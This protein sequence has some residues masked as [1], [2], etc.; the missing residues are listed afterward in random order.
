M[1]EAKAYMEIFVSTGA[2]NAMFTLRTT[3]VHSSRDFFFT[4]EAYIKNLSTDLEKAETLA[5]E[6]TKNLAEKIAS[7]DFE[8]YYTGPETEELRARRGKLSADE[9]AAIELIEAGVVPFGKHKNTNIS[10]LQDTYLCW[11]TDQL[12]NP[13]EQLKPAFFALCSIA[14]GVADERGLLAARQ[15]K[16]DARHEE[17]LKSAHFGEIGKR[18]V[19][20]VEVLYKNRDEF[21]GFLV[22]YKYTMKIG[23]NILTHNGKTDLP[24]GKIKLKFTVKFHNETSRG[25][26]RTYI[27]RPALEI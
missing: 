11:L 2:K 15:A 16:R 22:G 3:R 10:D 20:E 4:R 24:L 8:V 21:E 19:E 7:P 5:I 18:Y 12:K 6:Y 23:D 9:T 25:V 17:D 26:K 27:N 13:P 14:S 1:S